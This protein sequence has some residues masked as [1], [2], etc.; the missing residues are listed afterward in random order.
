MFFIL[1]Y[2]KMNKHLINLLKNFKQNR[3]RNYHANYKKT[4]FIINE[5]IKNE[6]QFDFIIIGGGSAGCVMAN[7]LSEITDKKILLLEAGRVDDH[8][9]ISIPAA[10]IKLFGSE[11]AFNYSTTPQKNK[12]NRSIY[13]P[14]GRVLGGSSSINAMAYL[15]GSA[16][17]YDEWEKYGE[18]WN[19]DECLKYFKK[20]ER[21]Q[22]SESEINKEF[23]NWTGPWKIGDVTNPHELTKLVIQAFNEELG[24]PLCNDFNGLRFQEEGVGLI[25]VNIAQGE[26]H[27]ISDAY[28]DQEVLSRDNLYVRTNSTVSRILIE[29]DSKTAYGVEILNS[30]GSISKIWA[31]NEVILSAGTFNSPRILMLSGVGNQSSLRQHDVPLVLDNPEVGR[32]LQDHPY[33]GLIRLLKNPIS[34]DVLNHFPNNLIALLKWKW[35]KNNELANCAE[36]TGYIKSETAKKNKEKAPDLQIGFIKSIFIDHGKSSFVGKYGYALGPILL[37]PSSK[38][39]I[40]LNS[41]NILDSPLIDLNI[42]NDQED[43]ERV[44]E[45]YK[46]AQKIIEGKVLSQVNDD[47]YLIPEKGQ[48]ETEEALR[49]QIRKHSQ[50][51]Y[52]PTSTCA[53]GKVVDEKLKVKGIKNLRVIDASIMPFLIR[54]NTNAPTVMI[55]EKASDMIK[56]EYKF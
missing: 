16:Y 43:F 40:D 11:Y 23:H 14:Q 45:G 22:R 32:N 12:D 19:F 33:V 30:D 42:Y 1:K 20:A 6:E 35:G 15:R 36:M 56:E 26:R 2:L 49:A 17:D 46:I 13:I 8:L 27:S 53:M 9:F 39:H 3:L 29:K 52:H 38:G 37:S 47:E 48:G 50:T 21:Q 54:S 7:R 10:G 41:K 25:Q 5:R 4:N 44:Y 24:L 18:G 55:A 51:L 28:L 34:L 31:K